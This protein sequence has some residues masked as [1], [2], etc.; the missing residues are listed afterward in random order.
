MDIILYLRCLL[1]TGLTLIFLRIKSKHLSSSMTQETMEEWRGETFYV[2]SDWWNMADVTTDDLVLTDPRVVLVCRAKTCCTWMFAAE[3]SD[4]SILTALIDFTA[5]VKEQWTLWTLGSRPR[6]TDCH[7][8]W[9]LRKG[10]VVL[11]CWTQQVTLTHLEFLWNSGYFHFQTRLMSAG[12]SDLNAFMYQNSCCC[13]LFCLLHFSVCTSRN[14]KE[15][16]S[17]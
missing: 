8:L 16:V 17:F 12:Q 6:D 10:K 11:S 9:W 13:S 4:S 2:A 14:K 1:W 7:H 3:G 5:A 15:P